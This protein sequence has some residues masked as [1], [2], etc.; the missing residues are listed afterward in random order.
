MKNLRSI[1][2]VPF[3]DLINLFKIKSEH[4]FLLEPN[5]G[6]G[7]VQVFNLEK[8]LQARLWNFNFKEGIELYSDL[9]NGTEKSYFNL[10]FFLNMQGLEFSSLKVPVQQNDIWDTIL[11]SATSDYEISLSPGA[12]AHCLSLSFSDTWLN[13]NVLQ[14]NEEFKRFKDLIY[15][16]D[17]LLLL[18]SM[19]TSEK[20]LIL[21]LFHDSWKKSLGSFYI[22]TVLFKII[23]D[24]FYRIKE[25]DSFS[26]NKLNVDA[27][28]IEIEK[29]LC[30]NLREMLPNLKD[31]AEK[32]SLSESTLKRHFRKKYGVNMSTYF[33]NKKMEYAER[34]IREENTNLAEIASRLGYRNVNNFIIMF[35]KRQE[36][37]TREQDENKLSKQN[38]NELTS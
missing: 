7:Y 31:L 28:I 13:N 26:I 30:N 24:F 3:N 20:K 34:L 25:R 11:I 5:V 36:G 29:Y 6:K 19:T 10:A 4:T 14:D 16:S 21:E 35:Q 33:I 23:S 12:K 38:Y 8:G 2:R 1:P 27:T 9:N 37:L 22:K 15:T 32:F 18:E 17:C